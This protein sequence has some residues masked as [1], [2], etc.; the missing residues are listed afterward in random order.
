MKPT[1]SKFLIDLALWSAAGL[2]AYGFRKPELL[3]RGVPS[4]VLGYLLLSL[5]VMAAL[6]TYYSLHRQSWQRVGILDLQLLGRAVTLATLVMFALGFILQTWL[7]LPRSVPV[8]AGVLGLLLMGGI[9]LVA[10]LTSER[11]RLQAAPQRQRVLI[12]GAG[13]AG[14]LI[15]REMQRHP[16]AGLEPIGFLDD[17]PRKIRGRVVGLPVFGPIDDLVTVAKREQAQE[18]L[19]A[20]PSADGQFVRRV[21]SLARDTG[22]RYRIIPG[23]FEILSSDVTISQI[24]D[25]NLED[26]LRRPPVRLNTAEIASYLKGRV[27]LVTGAGG[28]IGSEIIRQLAVFGPSTVLLFGRGENSIFSIQQE[29]LRTWP[30]IEQVGLIGDVRDAARLRA[31]FERYRPEVV[32][33]AAAHKHVP[34]M[35]EAPSEAILN[36]VIGTQNVV[37]LCLE[38]GVSRLVN[39]STDKAVNPTSV[40]GASKRVAEMV[41][42]A[43][44]ARARDAQAFV[45]VRFGNVLGSRGSV[46]PTFMAQI[47]AGGPITVTHPEMVRY[48]MTIPEAARLVLQAGGLAENGKVYVLDMGEPVKI[49]DLAHD[50]IRLSGAWNVDVV[51]SGIRPGEK[52]YEELLT[53]SEGADATTHSEIFSARL[54]QVNEYQIIDNVQALRS[55]AQKN[56]E[57]KIR[58]LLSEMI[59]ENKFGSIR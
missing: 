14:S 57:H 26:L 48:F 39:I 37:D 10:R 12:V 21:V 50:V 38:F 25:V 58:H 18:I 44:A 34:L 49:A 41:V 53:T 24:R 16:E 32:F 20:V 7:Q 11:V 29:L 33:H 40:M 6:E 13:D 27:I 35:E 36:N 1:T 22:L 55:A 3:S 4:N 17:E 30:E 56:D 9:R 46:V 31:V 19:I 45:S 15:A 59:P 8:M 2:L 52:L 47:R 42:S 51:Y 54:A 23:M 43:G 28:S 5:L